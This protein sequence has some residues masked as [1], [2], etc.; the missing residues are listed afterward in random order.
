[1]KWN[2]MRSRRR[3]TCNLKGYMFRLLEVCHHAIYFVSPNRTSIM[4]FINMFYIFLKNV[5]GL[6]AFSD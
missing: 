5:G 2:L 1:M 3:E 6:V 4:L